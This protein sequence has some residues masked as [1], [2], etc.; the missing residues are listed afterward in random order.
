[1]ER[2]S[3]QAAVSANG[4]AFANATVRV[5]AD[6]DVTSI[7]SGAT[8]ANGQLTFDDL[9]AGSY[10]VDLILPAGFELVSG[11]TLRRD[12][13]VEDE[14]TTAVTFALQA[15]VVPPTEGSVRVTV[16][17]GA[18]GVEGVQV[19]L[20]ASGG[21][22]ALDTRAT[23]ADGR[24]IFEELA[25]GAYD[26]AIELTADLEP[27]AGDSV[28]KAVT[29]TAGSVTDVQFGVASTAPSTVEISASGTSF[30]PA[31]VTIEPGTTVRWIKGIN[32]HTVTPSG[33]SEWTA[34]TLDQPAETFEHTFAQVGTFPYHCE[35]HSGMTG[36]IRVQN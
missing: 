36:V 26:V 17:D 33:H 12:V 9:V 15:I 13:V 28:R 22:S 24:A 7:R 4:A 30:S 19:S 10:D 35:F 20:F 16:R 34:V 31:D 32:P 8:G 2:G 21:V 1:V 25:P 27:A 6:G 29:V 11:Q 3:I 23:A 14:E 18:I 5:F